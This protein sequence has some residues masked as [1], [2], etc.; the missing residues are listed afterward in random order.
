MADCGG[1]L[2]RDGELGCH[3][4]LGCDELNLEVA[5]P[6]DGP[7]VVVAASADEPMAERVRVGSG[8]TG[9]P[10]YGDGRLRRG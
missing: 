6:A 2:G 1:E 3:G 9:R 7:T 5:S 8:G 10:R 4:E